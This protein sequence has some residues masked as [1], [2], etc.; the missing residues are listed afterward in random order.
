MYTSLVREE[1]NSRLKIIEVWTFFSV[2][3]FDNMLCGFTLLLI[4]AGTVLFRKQDK[5][6]VTILLEVKRLTIFQLISN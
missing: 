2:F 3:H 1:T 4:D 5:L 6:Y